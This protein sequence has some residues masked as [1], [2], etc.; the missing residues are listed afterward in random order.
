VEV[1]QFNIN[2]LSGDTVASDGQNPDSPWQYEDYRLPTSTDTCVS[3]ARGG[4]SLGFI[5]LNRSDDG[6]PCDSNPQPASPTAVSRQWVITIADTASCGILAA[7]DSRYLSPASYISGP[8]TLNGSDLSR[9]RIDNLFASKL[10]ATS[11]V[12]F[13]LK[14]FVGGGVGYEIRSVT[15]AQI[16]GTADVRTVAYEGFGRLWEITPRYKAISVA[17]PMRVHMT[18]QRTNM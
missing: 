6:A 10:P 11:A 13:L 14:S 3:A 2:Y 17:F 16:L 9:I 8:C 15:K 4:G 1:L 12:D 18:L 7:Y 5:S